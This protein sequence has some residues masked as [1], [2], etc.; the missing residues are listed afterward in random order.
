MGRFNEAAAQEHSLRFLK[1]RKVFGHFKK[2]KV[3]YF[4]FSLLIFVEVPREERFISKS[5]SYIRF[6]RKCFF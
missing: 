4:F 1:T 3:E 5:T 2:L 6:D